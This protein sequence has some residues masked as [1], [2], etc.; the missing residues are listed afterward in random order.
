MPFLIL[1]TQ[2]SA[3]LNSNRMR[4]IRGERLRTRSLSLRKQCQYL[5]G[6][7][8]DSLVWERLLLQTLETTLMSV[9]AD[10]ARWEIFITRPKWWCILSVTVNV[11]K[12]IQ[13]LKIHL[14]SIIYTSKNAQSG[15]PVEDPRLEPF[16]EISIE[17]LRRKP[18]IFRH[19]C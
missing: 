5:F 10:I 14:N 8:D 18:I 4:K 6:L 11:I 15:E 1:H 12:S 9:A 19:H 17:I 13:F 16:F 3:A 2:L 7:P